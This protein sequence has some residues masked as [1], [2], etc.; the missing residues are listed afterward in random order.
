MSGAFEGWELPAASSPVEG[1]KFFLSLSLSRS[2]SLSLTHTH[3]HTHTYARTHAHTHTHTYIYIYIYIY[4]SRP[5]AVTSGVRVILA[6][7]G[8]ERGAMG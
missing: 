4:E 2:L 1:M 7:T 6:K 8:R 3:T 5:V